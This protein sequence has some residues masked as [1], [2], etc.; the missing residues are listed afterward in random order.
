MLALLGCSLSSMHVLLAGVAWWFPPMLVV[1]IVLA[2]GVLARRLS[3]RVWSGAVA[4]AVAYPLVLSLVFSPGTALLGVVPLP[5]TVDAWHSLL[6][7]GG[8][9]IAHQGVPAHADAGIVFILAVAAGGAAVLAELLVHTVRAPALAAVPALVLLAGPVVILPGGSDALCFV[10]TAVAYLVVLHAGSRLP[11]ARAAVAGGGLAL[12]IGLLVP[13]VLPDV[14]ATPPSTGTGGGVEIGVNPIVDLGDDLRRGE[15]T[16]AYT[17]R[18]TADQG[19]YFTLT[20]IEDLSGQQWGPEDPMVG[21]GT[22][23]DRLDTPPG[24]TAD[25]Q[26]APFTTSVSMGLLVGTW[27]PTPYPAQ[28]ITGLRGD[29][30][31]DTRTLTV[32]TDDSSVRAQ[33]YTVTSLDVQPTADQLRAADP[34]VPSDLDPLVSVPRGMPDIIA[35]T[36]REVTADATT[37]YDRAIALQSYFH[38][39]L[40]TYSEDAPVTDGYDGTGVDVVARFLRE[41]SGYCVH[42]ASAMALMARSLGIPARVA[43]GFQPGTPQYS[44]N[45]RVLDYV[46]TTHDFHAWPEL[47]FSGVGWVRFEPTPSRGFVPD[48]DTS[49]ATGTTD[50]GV[51]GSAPQA[52]ATPQASAPT[53]SASDEGVSAASGDTGM[54]MAPVLETAVVVLVVLALLLTPALWRSA[55]RRRRLALLRRAGPGAVAAAWDEVRESAIDLGIPAPATET[56]RGFAARVGASWPGRERDALERVLDAVERSAYAPGR[57]P[58]PDPTDL[59][60]VR[61]GLALGARPLARLLASVAPRSLLPETWR[62][63][64]GALSGGPEGE[65]EHGHGRAL[66]GRR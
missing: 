61:A 3:G 57:A 11:H 66:S 27:L 42:F 21:A 18:T 28:S 16:T 29:W 35:R 56:P 24:L 26:A 59:A 55:R 7:A 22:S 50:P 6:V 53:P 37:N 31:A 13:Y 48:Y 2:A 15:A 65:R 36:A 64:A 52:T 34:S 62:G 23:V 10:L 32:H 9:S 30:T 4:S 44:T 12:A 14:Q 45:G 38:S 60:L 41:R 58:A 19:L 49:V 54:D 17:Y 8:A 46:V 51:T 25:V 40:F 5:A 43:V 47:Y 20:T 33:R 63:E 1:L 39:S